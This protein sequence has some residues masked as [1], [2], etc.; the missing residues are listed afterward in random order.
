MRAMPPAFWITIVLML[1]VV[2]PVLIAGS[3]TPKHD[4]AHAAADHH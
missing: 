4:D 2:I 1:L 3:R